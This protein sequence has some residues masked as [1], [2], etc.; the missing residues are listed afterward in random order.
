MKAISI[1]G[2]TGSIG[3]QAL[4][5]ISNFPEK[6]RVTGL[7]AGSNIELLAEQ[8]KKFRPEI[9]SVG[10]EKSIKKLKEFLG[11]YIPEVYSALKVL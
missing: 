3:R 4:E 7:A 6:F 5:V 8:I 10:E 9:V 11:E 2:S 1:L